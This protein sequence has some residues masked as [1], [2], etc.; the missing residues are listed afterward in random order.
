MLV[1][2]ELVGGYI[3]PLNAILPRF[4]ANKAIIGILAENVLN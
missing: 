4:N 3:K 2:L 1:R